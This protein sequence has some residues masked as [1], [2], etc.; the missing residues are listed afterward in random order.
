MS[1][2]NIAIKNLS[3][4]TLGPE[5]LLQYDIAAVYGKAAVYDIAEIL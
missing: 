5:G 4:G 1:E 2:L 3:Y